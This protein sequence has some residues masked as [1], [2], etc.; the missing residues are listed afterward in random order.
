MQWCVGTRP[1]GG[2]AGAGTRCEPEI[3]ASYEGVGDMA[4]EERQRAAAVT[5]LS[6]GSNMGDTAAN[7]A[8]ARE[9]IADLTD[10]QVTAESSLYHTAPVGK[11]DQDW[12]LN[13]VLRV[14][15]RLEPRELL[16]SCLAI[17][18]RLGRV[19][20]E[21]W[22]PRIID[23][24]LLVY[25]DVTSDDAELT[26]PH[27]RLTER[28]FVLVPLVELEPSLSVGGRS[29]AELLTALPETERRGV[30]RYES[31]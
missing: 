5:Y 17:E 22:G 16:R 12:F 3:T 4:A 26:L 24:D 8:A 15:T 30:V 19:R 27:P 2:V 7:L 31:A 23:I 25:D 10:T 18:T 28:A 21:R 11:T 29:V 14:E 1:D 13:Q 6:L 20:V 9:A